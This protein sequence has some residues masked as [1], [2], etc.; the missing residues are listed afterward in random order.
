M[1]E[2]LMAFRSGDQ[3]ETGQLGAL[4][5]AE[6]FGNLRFLAEAYAKVHKATPGGK[7]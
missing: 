3:G 2:A 1:A 5:I 7:K 6:A 4:A